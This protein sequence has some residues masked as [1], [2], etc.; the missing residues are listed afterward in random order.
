MPVQ[1]IPAF[2]TNGFT[3]HCFL[4]SVA[5][6]LKP[7]VYVIKDGCSFLQFIIE[8]NNTSF[9]GSFV[10]SYDPVLFIQQYIRLVCI[11]KNSTQIESDTIGVPR[12]Q[13]N[14]YHN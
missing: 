14:A 5:E 7:F 13:S 4:K 11:I 2:S 8:I 12:D 9:A 6:I 3:F 1:F 10:V